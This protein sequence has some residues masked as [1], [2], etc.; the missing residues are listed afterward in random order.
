VLIVDAHEDLAWSAL[1]FCRDYTLSS[2]Q[3]RLREQNTQIPVYNDDSMLGWPD[4]QLGQVALVFATLYA[5][6]IRWRV[7]D[8]DRLCYQDDRQAGHLFRQQLDFYVQ[9]SDGH[10]D[11]FRQI[12]SRPDLQDLFRIWE[13]SPKLDE[14]TG[15][16]KVGNPVGLLLLMEGAD[17]VRDPGELDEWWHDG[18]RII[19]PAWAG[20]RYCGGNKEPGPLTA[21]GFTLLERMA[22]LGFGLDLSHM[23]EKAVLQALEVYPGAIMATHSN[24]Q[25][26]L[27]GD[28]TNR[29]LSDR[30]IHGI[31]ERGGVIG[32]HLFNAFLKAGWVRGDP[33]VAIGLERVIQQID[34]Y[35]QIAGNSTQVG[36]GSD[37]DGGLGL[38]SVPVGI[39]SIADLQKIAPLLIERGYTTHDSAAILGLNWLS[40]ASKILPE[41][42]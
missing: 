42:L 32:V 9:L 18:V 16:V 22:E 37:F 5:T 10:S 27:K 20:T 4:Y 14:A 24:A 3:I 29:H 34:Y 23:D 6:P 13:T 2:A 40:L 30:V 26:L 41:S 19:G 8:W 36:I 31:L 17:A 7:G 21:A 25:A 15:E 39:D 1:S 35:C 12:R 11:K 28:Q 33:R 38:Q